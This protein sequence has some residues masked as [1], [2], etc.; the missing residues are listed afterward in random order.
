MWARHIKRYRKSWESCILMRDLVKNKNSKKYT[1][2]KLFAKREE[3][4]IL[5]ISK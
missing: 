2:D 4:E 3:D 5:W 1:V